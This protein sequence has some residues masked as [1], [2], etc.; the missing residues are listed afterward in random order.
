[1]LTGCYLPWSE[2][3]EHARGK[4]EVPPLPECGGPAPVSPHL[5]WETLLRSL[6]ECPSVMSDSWPPCEWTVAQPG[7][8]AHGILQARILEWVATSFSRGSS[9]PRNRTQGLLHCRQ[10]LYRLSQQADSGC[11]LAPFYFIYLIG[12]QFLYN[13]CVSFCCTMKW[14]SYMYT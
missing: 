8:S 3:G 10:I 14:I 7:F 6:H 4:R 2:C 13:G 11:S 12:V 1:M 5:I 9:W